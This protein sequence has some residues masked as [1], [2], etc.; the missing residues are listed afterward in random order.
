MLHKS[1]GFIGTVGGS[2]EWG[3][4]APCALYVPRCRGVRNGCHGGA[5][6]VLHAMGTVQFQLSV[7]QTRVEDITQAVTK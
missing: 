3:G 1:Q 5:I 4:K 2:L 7:N 6:G